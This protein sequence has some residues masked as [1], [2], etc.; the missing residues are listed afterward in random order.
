MRLLY[1]CHGQLGDAVSLKREH[2][3]FLQALREAYDDDPDLAEPEPETAA[4]FE[5]VLAGLDAGG[6]M[7]PPGAVRPHRAA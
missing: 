5:E 7:R 6:T 4:V 2:R 3:R 1:R